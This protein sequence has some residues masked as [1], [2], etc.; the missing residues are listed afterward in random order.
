M[1]SWP[2]PILLPHSTFDRKSRPERGIAGAGLPYAS[3][4]TPPIHRL[5]ATDSLQNGKIEYN[6]LELPLGLFFAYPSWRDDKLS[7]HTS[8]FSK[9]PRPER[10]VSQL[11]TVCRVKRREVLKRMPLYLVIFA[12]KISAGRRVSL[13]IMENRG[14]S[15]LPE[16]TGRF[17]SHGDI[18]CPIDRRDILHLHRKTLRFAVVNIARSAAT[19]CPC[20]SHQLSGF[21]YH[22]MTMNRSAAQVSAGFGLSRDGVACSCSSSPD[23]HTGRHRAALCLLACITQNNSA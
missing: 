18:Q 12:P 9:S 4:A 1:N 22:S 11:V 2:T 15:A 17:S 14:S 13:E 8:D 23:L 5:S 19:P 10:V 6:S 3:V 21:G 20:H 7:C 16:Q